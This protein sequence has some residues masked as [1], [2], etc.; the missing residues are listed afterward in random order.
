MSASV[1]IAIDP[2]RYKVGVAVVERQGKVLYRAVLTVQEL[3]AQ[4]P[5]LC[6]RFR[7]EGIVVGDG[8]GWRIIQPMLSSLAAGVPVHVVDES[9]TSEEARR[10]YLRENA[11][12]GW[13]R[14]LP[15]WLRV[16]DQP[17]DDYV[18]V[19]LAERYWQQTPQGGGL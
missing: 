19:I 1:V 9:F 14:L 17:Y 15:P 10:R 12:R 18:A 7:P 13:R 3:Q 16:P 2:G 4:L 11:P 5:E 6:A 8:T